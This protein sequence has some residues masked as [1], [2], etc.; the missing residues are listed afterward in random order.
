[1]A[2]G[3]LPAHPGVTVTATAV[4]HPSV[5]A[6]TPDTANTDTTGDPDG[7]VAGLTDRL[8]QLYQR[9]DHAGVCV[10]DGYGIAIR[11]HGGALEIDDGLG[12]F[13]RRRRYNRATHGLTRVVILGDAGIISIEA[14]RWLDA[15]GI[16]LVVTDR[17][18]TRPLLVTAARDSDDARI[19]RVQA[20]AVD[21][22]VGVVIARALI[23][24]KIT[25][26]ARV[27]RDRFGNVEQADNLDRLAAAVET[28]TTIGE[29]RQLEAVAASVYW[30]AWSD[31]PATIPHFTVPDRRRVP[32]HWLRYDT[33][34]S[35]LGS[36]NGN[37]AAERPTNAL[38]NYGFAL[39]ETEATIACRAVG[40]D[41]GLGI[42]HADTRGRASLAL[43]LLEAV[44]PAVETYVL[45]LLAERTF[46]RADFHELPDGQVRLVGAVRHDLATT[47][48]LWRETVAPW[49]ERVARYVADD[50]TGKIKVGAPLSGANRKAAAAEVIARVAAARAAKTAPTRQQPRD[51]RTGRYNCPGCGAPVTNPRR[52]RCDACVSADP[53]HS[54]GLRQSR[55]RAISARRQAEAGWSAHHPAGPLDPAWWEDTCRPRLAEV[56]VGAIMRACGVSKSSAS[57]WRSGKHVPHPMHWETL[58]GLAG[59]A[60]PEPTG[61]TE[62]VAS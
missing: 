12:P 30:A 45:D 47:L 22:P 31:H 20:A 44:R 52:V 25:G 37:R 14:F 16:P 36:A 21:R 49:A 15:L 39:A 29:V 59:V 41:A 17:H 57:G 40:L 6:T 7:T 28:A 43:D 1:M 60:P 13:R 61:R 34:R 23:E 55:A 9:D 35:T 27:A 46:T 4:H 8:G 10:A 33:R 2:G 53:S 48:P 32:A 19:R 3:R 38:L 51:E 5:A 26:H 54:P 50:A 56:K 18:T 42:V 24:A 11:V 62:G 58:A